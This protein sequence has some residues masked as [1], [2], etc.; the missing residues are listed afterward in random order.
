M[1]LLTALTLNMAADPSD[2]QFMPKPTGHGFDDSGLTKEAGFSENGQMDRFGIPDLNNPVTKELTD[3]D[4]ELASEGANVFLAVLFYSPTMADYD[5]VALHWEKASM[6]LRQVAAYTSANITMARFDISEPEHKELA[7]RYDVSPDVTTRPKM[8]LFTN[9]AFLVD[10]SCPVSH[11]EIRQ[12]VLAQTIPS[13]SVIDN[14]SELR[15]WKR[16]KQFNQANLKFLAHFTE[17]ESPRAQQFVSVAN[18]L[19]Q[20]VQF[21]IVTDAALFALVTKKNKNKTEDDDVVSDGAIVMFRDFDDVTQFPYEGAVTLAA[22]ISFLRQHDVPLLTDLGD[23][24]EFRVRD[25]LSHPSPHRLLLFFKTQADLD[26]KRPDLLTLARDLRPETLVAFTLEQQDD[27]SNFDYTFWDVPGKEPAL[28]FLHIHKDRKYLYTGPDALELSTIRQFLTD[29]ET[30]RITP[31]LKSQ[32]E[33]VSNPGPLKIA[34]TNTYAAEVYDAP[35]SDSLVLFYAPG[36]RDSD[37]M[38]RQLEAF[39]KVWRREKRMS[40]YGV[41]VHQNDVMHVEVG[42]RLPALFYV[43]ADSKAKR[44]TTMR[45]D[46]I[47]YPDMTQLMAFVTNHTHFRDLAPDAKVWARLLA[48]DE[49]L[50]ARIA[51]ADTTVVVEDPAV[52]IVV[53]DPTTVVPPQAE[54][55]EVPLEDEETPPQQQPDPSSMFGPEF[56]K[57]K[58]KML[59][60]E[61]QQ[62]QPEEEEEAQVYSGT[63]IENNM[64]P[65]S[66]AEIQAAQSIL[67][68]EISSLLKSTGFSLP[69]DFDETFDPAQATA[70]IPWYSALLFLVNVFMAKVF[71]PGLMGGLYVLLLLTLVF[72]AL[73]FGWRKL[74]E[75]RMRQF[76]VEFYEQNGLKDRLNR[77]PTIVAA[78]SQMSNG[79]AKLKE[80]LVRKHVMA[81]KKKNQ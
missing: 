27:G 18:R 78:Y 63:A 20:K 44:E 62:Q 13:V 70:G 22:M 68:T 6:E 9:G 75:R 25:L 2:S 3:L 56:E 55:E 58:R 77:V 48:E 47:T 7:Q 72:V 38:K 4:F 42:P 15:K 67:K 41:D 21:A 29:V 51:Q 57:L 46:H 33:P 10:I 23:P 76:L 69:A 19:R 17:I 28:L 52:D 12:F 11:T 36:Q 37:W 26:A 35:Q 49:E 60:D 45:L 31:K 1:L 81:D 30:G 61:E 39:A 32:V 16:R 14:V 24:L 80:D 65:G 34:T 74:R 43:S 66:F 54:E 71:G 53:E 8:K 5:F 59:S 40:V 79:L 50:K 64:F 73:P